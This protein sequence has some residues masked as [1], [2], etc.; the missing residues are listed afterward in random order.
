MPGP[1]PEPD[2]DDLESLRAKHQEEAEYV[3]L[4]RTNLGNKEYI[5]RIGLSGADLDAI[6]QRFGGGTYVAE[7]CRR[8]GKFLDRCEFRVA[9]KPKDDAGVETA[10][11]LPPAQSMTE[12]LSTMKAI[13]DEVRR[14]PPAAAQGNP[15]EMAVGLAKTMHEATQPYLTALLERRDQPNDSAVLTA[16]QTG[17]ELAREL[18][19]GGSSTT[20]WDRLFNELVPAIR[21]AQEPGR[22]G[23]PPTPGAPPS[24]W[25]Q[26]VAPFVAQLNGLAQRGTD[27]LVYASVLEDTAPPEVLDMLI[28]AVQGPSF[29]AEFF[30]AFPETR[31]AREWWSGLVGGLL[32]GIDGD[33]VSNDHD[34]A[35]GRRGDG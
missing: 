29:W 21:S 8:G 4:Y 35:T 14:P 9:G 26:A 10:A 23:V 22:P 25:R 13:L 6:R 30:A 33:D 34:V 28:E 5:A 32:E 3:R 1:E 17:V 15:L 27:P 20:P 31:H 12:L 19:A 24:D 7:F 11:D 18:G 16:L 2:R